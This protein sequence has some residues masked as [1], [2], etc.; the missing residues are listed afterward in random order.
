M[1]G[2]TY[3]PSVAILQTLMPTSLADSMAN[4]S[5]ALRL[6]YSLRKL[7]GFQQDKFTTKAWYESLYQ[8]PYNDLDKNPQDQSNYSNSNNDRLD[9]RNFKDILLAGELDRE[10]KWDKWCE[11]FIN[12]YAKQAGKTDR[13]LQ[14]FIN[15]LN[16]EFPFDTTGKTIS[17]NLKTLVDRGFLTF[18]R[19]NNVFLLPDTFPVIEIASQSA[20]VFD[21]D[22]PYLMDDFSSFARMFAEPLQAVQRFHLYADYQTIDNVQSKITEYQNKLRE[23]WQTGSSLPCELTYQSASQAKAYSIVVYPVCI[24]YYQRSFYLCAFEYKENEPERSWYNYRLDRIQELIC[25]DWEKDFRIIH[26]SLL[27]THQKT[28]DSE[29]I[30]EIQDA[31]AE[32]YGFDFYRSPKLMLL[33]FDRDFHDRYI[34]NTWRHDT[35]KLVNRN[36]IESLIKGLPDLDRTLITDKIETYPQDAYY[37]MNYRVGDNSVIMRLRAWCPNVEVLLP[38]DLRDRMREDMRQ[39]W[40]LYREDRIC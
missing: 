38:L 37:R 5:K 25:L 20:S 12:Y 16:R 40:E 2:F 21:R 4:I 14:D 3:E 10:Q 17:N 36:K 27:E 30:D 19:N 31:L 13:Y 24:Y 8:F 28:N 11:D 6:W 33:R 1:R 9:T 26:P 29:L 34:K 7:D 22:T 18:D 23:I 15:R 35:F 39:T 32:A